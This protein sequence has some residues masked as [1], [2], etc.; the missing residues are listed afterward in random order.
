MNTFAKSY[1]CGIAALSLLLAPG[2]TVAVADDTNS[3]EV[4]APA[5]SPV[6][7]PEIPPSVELC[8]VSVDLDR[9]DMYERFDREITSMAYS[10][11]TTMA[12]LKRANR[13]FPV[14][15]P[16]LKEEGVPLDMLYLACIESSLHPRAR[17]GA[18]AA[19]FWQI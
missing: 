16:I 4:T 8:G 11:G 13:Y 18:G 3:A 1:I 10:H 5:F 2:C 12:I 9:E 7:S 15:A 6:F 14:M 17:S 19:G